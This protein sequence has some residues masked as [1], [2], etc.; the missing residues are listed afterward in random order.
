MQ[1]NS[2]QDDA[3]A[4]RTGERAAAGGRAGLAENQPWARSQAALVRESLV[5]C[6]DA[7]DITDQ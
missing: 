2:E 5:R 6:P 3:N 1:E 7:R 4:E